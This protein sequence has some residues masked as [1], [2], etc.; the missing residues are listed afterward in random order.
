MTI[1][2][3]L[4]FEISVSVAGTDAASR[5]VHLDMKLS[6]ASEAETVVN[7][8]FAV[9]PE[10]GDVRPEVSAGGRSIPFRFRVRLAALKPSDFVR[11]APGETAE[12]RYL[13]SCGYDLSEPGEYSVR[14][15][16]VNKAKPEDPDAGAV[17]VGELE[18]NSTTFSVP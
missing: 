13:L 16:Y 10:I 1:V 12:G 9:A 11:L 15:V 14:A 7:G 18:S 17:F 6:N 3:D 8:R 2:T 4:S 5:E